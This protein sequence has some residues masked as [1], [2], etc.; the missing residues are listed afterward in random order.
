MKIR[1]LLNNWTYAGT[2]RQI[3]EKLSRDAHGPDF[4]SLDAYME[5]V[6]KIY[7]EGGQ[8]DITIA[9]DTLENRC[10]S[11]I[12]GLVEN[13]EAQLVLEKPHI[14]MYAI[15]ILRRTTGLT[16]EGLAQKLR[17]SFASVNGWERG[18]HSLKSGA[19]IH[20]LQN[21]AK[22]VSTAHQA[23]N[24]IRSRQRQPINA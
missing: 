7:R 23:V 18:K 9:G 17:V 12:C 21:L 22:R 10:E 19:V 11:F 16:Q 15:R 24:A 14:D 13:F 5:E 6:V 20:T 2:P 8:A 1:T 4:S 3:V